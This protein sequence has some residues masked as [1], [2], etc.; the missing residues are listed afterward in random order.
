M[1]WGDSW[2]S[3]KKANWQRRGKP[4]WAA[5][6]WKDIA[7]RVEKLPV[8]VRHVDAHVPKS[9]ANEEHRNNEQVL[10]TTQAVIRTKERGGIDTSRIKG[11]V[12]EP[13]EWTITSEP[14]DT[15]LTL[16][17]GLG[18]LS[19][20]FWDI[21]KSM[22]PRN[23]QLLS[24]GPG[25]GSAVLAPVPEEEEEEEEEEDL[26]RRLK[27][28]F[29]SPCDKYQACGR[30]PVKLVLQLAKIVLV[31]VQK[32]FNSML[33]VND[34]DSDSDNDSDKDNDSDSVNDSESENDSESDTDPRNGHK[35]IGDWEWAGSP[36]M[37]TDLLEIGNRHGSQ[38]W[39]QRRRNFGK[40]GQA[41]ASSGQCWEK[42]LQG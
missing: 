9:R 25:Y 29:M 30:R 27:Y 21:D 10:L 35:S 24:R 17:Q 8:K 31:T 11:P 14:G 32:H 7:T 15:K 20:P 41:P 40:C 4:I 26:R 37:G 19:F 28:F 6:E 2:R 42:T 3:G 5:D 38:S 1:L 22:C 33:S 12:E 16:K 39:H 36:G 23:E 18:V 34:N 13:K